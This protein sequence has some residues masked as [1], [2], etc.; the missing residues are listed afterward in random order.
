MRVWGRKTSSNVQKVL[1]SLEEIGQPY[2]HEIVGGIYG[3]K[4][5]IEYASKT[6]TKLVPV[7]EDGD[8]ALWESHSIIRY[9]A[10]KFPNSTIGIDNDRRDAKI[11]CWIDYNSSAFQPALIGL[12]WEMVR[13]P[14]AQRSKQNEEK[15][16]KS[17]VSSAAILSERLQTHDFLLDSFSIADI[18][19]GTLLYRMQEVAPD[20]AAIPS[21]TRWY[22]RLIERTGYTKFV[23]TSYEELRATD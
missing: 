21:L 1:W 22:N 3:G 12:F 15:H 14:S 13:T 19:T 6:P 2:E 11:S 18:S 10:R 4:D 9:L 23:T 8:L 5:R 20:I 17:L 16:Y 7:L